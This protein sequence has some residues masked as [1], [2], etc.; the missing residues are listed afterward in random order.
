MKQLINE[1]NR[2]LATTKG[3]ETFIFAYNNPHLSSGTGCVSVGEE[4]QQALLLAGVVNGLSMAA[5][6]TF[7]S[8]AIIDDPETFIATTLS[9]AD[10][11]KKRKEQVDNFF[12]ICYSVFSE[13]PLWLS[14][15]SLSSSRKAMW[16]HFS[17]LS[18]D[19]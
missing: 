10:Q 16:I 17:F 13:Y 9:Y 2:Q 19:F 1:F 15:L 6:E 3:D 18:Y 4:E 7:F 12:A 5:K 14:L 8:R 11:M